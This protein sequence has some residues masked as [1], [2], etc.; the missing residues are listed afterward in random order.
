MGWHESATGPASLSEF[1]SGV[2]ASR[3]PSDAPIAR[4][5]P[6]SKACGIATFIEDLLY[7]ET[8]ISIIIDTGSEGMLAPASDLEQECLA[9]PD[10]FRAKYSN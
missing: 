6:N 8:N 10:A 3:L 9:D 7:V 5:H 4:E 1:C 2:Y